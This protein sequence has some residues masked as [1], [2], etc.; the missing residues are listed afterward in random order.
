M[1]PSWHLE[2]A[3]LIAK[4]APY[5][6]YKPSR[7]IIAKLE[8]GNICKMIFSF[9][10]DN[11]EHPAAER[12]WVIIDTIDNEQFTGRLDNV[13]LYI[14]DL[15]YEDVVTFGPEH[16]VDSDAADDEPNLPATYLA[17]CLATNR[18]IV[19]KKRIG[20]LYREQPVEGAVKGHPDS[21]WRFMEGDEEQAYVDN[22]ANLQF[23]SLGLILNT[24]DSFLDLLS[25]PVGAAFA[26]EDETDQFIK[27]E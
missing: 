1:I 19:D 21:G 27:L 10:S 17:R 6:F 20:Y 22:S 5:T 14:T 12:M 16:I 11:P 24:D 23:V 4:A 13:P 9:R 18:I 3:D 8:P 26:R 2:N 7:R 15:K 25:A